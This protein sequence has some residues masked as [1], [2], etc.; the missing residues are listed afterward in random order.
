MHAIS[1]HWQSS[2]KRQSISGE[3]SLRSVTIF[4]NPLELQKSIVVCVSVET[5]GADLYVCEK[6]IE[7]LSGPL[8][9]FNAS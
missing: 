2:G 3:V 9:Q 5:C 1:P 6:G 4:H 7:T 8:M